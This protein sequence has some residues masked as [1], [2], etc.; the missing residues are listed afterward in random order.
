MSRCGK[1]ALFDHEAPPEPKWRNWWQSHEAFQLHYARIAQ[2]TGCVM[3]IAGCEMVMAERKSDEWRALIQKIKSVYSGPVSYN[4]D[5]YQENNVTWWDCVDVISSSG[6]YPLGSWDKELDRIEKVVR[7]YNKPF[8]FA[9][10]GSMS[11]EGSSLLPND[12]TLMQDDSRSASESDQEAWYID[13]FAATKKREWVRG[14]GLW[15]WDSRIHSEAEAKTGK[16]YEIYLKRAENIV[17]QN[18]GGLT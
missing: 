15:S 14:Y 6:Y 3:F 4:T 2:D 11:L 18:F 16:G 17:R 13:M 10:A 7:Q 1:T 9:E 12:W 5:K 8:F